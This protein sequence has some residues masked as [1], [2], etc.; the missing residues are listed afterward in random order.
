MYMACM[1]SVAKFIKD[2]VAEM[3]VAEVIT[4]GSFGT[5]A[6]KERKAVAKALSRLVKSGEINALCRGKF[7]KPDKCQYGDLPL[8]EE[9]QLRSLLR[10][11]YISGDEAF[12]R[13]GITTQVPAEV[14]IAAPGSTYSIK[15]GPMRVRYI[16]SRVE[17]IPEKTEL[18]VILDAL[19]QIKKIQDTSVK[20][21]IAFVV[22][23]IKNNSTTEINELTQLA[24]AYPPRVRALLGSLLENSGFNSQ[25][26]ELMATLNPLS[27]YSLGVKDVLPNY[28]KWGFK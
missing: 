27:R 10:G 26:E 19:M 22:D 8:T 23:K 4:Y 25:S 12:N 15:I 9:E 17:S 16:R 5:L 18:M 2:R 21:V 7:Y 1:E 14:V 3:P 13:I 28:K 6:L 24:M 20:K 11:G